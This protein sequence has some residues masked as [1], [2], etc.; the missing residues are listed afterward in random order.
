MKIFYK[1]SPL[2]E[3]I[4]LPLIVLSVIFKYIVLIRR[5]LYRR[6]MIKAYKAKAFTISVG[7][8]TVG[9]TGKTPMVIHL[10]QILKDKRIAVISRGYGSHGKGIRIVSDG[11][12]IMCN[13]DLCGDEPYLI[14]KSVNYAIVAVGNKRI[15]VIKT[16]E[17]KYNPD[18]IIL[19][20][21]FSHLRVKRDIDILLFDGDNGIGNGHLLPAGPLREPLNTIKY[22]S[23]IG[24]KGNNQVI[25]NTIKKYYQ[26]GPT[27]HFNY[28]FNTLKTVDQDEDVDVNN[29]KDKKVVCMAGIAFPDSFFMLLHS[30]GLKPTDC[31]PM[32][33][34]AEYNIDKLD[35]IVKKFK[36]DV[37]VI[38]AKDAVKIKQ[39]KKDS[40]VMWLYADVT[41]E[42]NN[43][44]RSLLENKYLNV[45]EG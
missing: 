11:H 39:L 12:N 2:L 21:G 10:C 29:I 18:I 17:A 45:K 13:S 8:I 23:F 5:Q 4:L 33:D 30:I 20:D 28:K 9:G 16:V 1:K 34:H 41:M 25:K 7:N 22:A 44:L 36:P 43:Q 38:T 32:P 35:K 3:L 19:D 42:D 27:F 40:N 15:D 26:S 6:N 31:I 37:I 14:A 24:I